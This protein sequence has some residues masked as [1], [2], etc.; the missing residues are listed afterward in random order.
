MPTRL[1]LYATVIALAPTLAL[2]QNTVGYLDRQVAPSNTVITSPATS[3][4]AQPGD[5]VM[6]EPQAVQQQNGIRYILGGVGD[7]E[8]AALRAASASYNVKVLTTSPTGH[9]A[10]MYKLTLAN[11]SGTPLVSVEND[12]PLFYADVPAGR[13]SVTVQSATTAAQTKTI[14]VASGKRQ[15][16]RF[17]VAGEE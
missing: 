4:P 5:Y 12:G 1:S 2:A 14:T 15:E 7:E 10:G 3:N 6:D 16:V 13:Y 11:V 9:F 8:E 17:H